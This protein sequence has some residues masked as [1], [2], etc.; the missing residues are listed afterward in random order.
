MKLFSMKRKLNFLFIPAMVI[1]L[2][3][4]VVKAYA[5]GGTD[6]ATIDAEL[7]I[8]CG[9]CYEAQSIWV[10]EDSENGYPYWV[11]GEGGFGG[12][13]YY[14]YPPEDH[15]NVIKDELM[16]VCPVGVFIKNW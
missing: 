15:K 12:L 5:S 1:T 4:V 2:A 11:H 16:E 10:V 9:A 3:L 6:I 14:N 8:N 7:C 13:L